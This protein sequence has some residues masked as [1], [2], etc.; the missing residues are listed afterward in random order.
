MQLSI[1]N[2]ALLPGP[3]L[4]V[5]PEIRSNIIVV[6]FINSLVAALVWVLLGLR[7][8]GLH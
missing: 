8:V 7:V 2:L 1:I 5:Y 4:E 6:Q 3:P